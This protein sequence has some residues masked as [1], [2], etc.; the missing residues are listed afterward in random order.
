MTKEELI[1][2]LKD[3]YSLLTRKETIEEKSF[4]E[5]YTYAVNRMFYLI[6]EL[7]EENEELKSI[8]SDYVN[9]VLHDRKEIDRL[10]NIIKEVRE[11]IENENTER[12]DN[13]TY[14]FALNIRKEKILEILDKE[15]K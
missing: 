2:A 1:K 6:E 15:N 3:G 10:N 12:F 5:G 13:P 4:E 11:Y 8:I 7:Q 9:I 14:E